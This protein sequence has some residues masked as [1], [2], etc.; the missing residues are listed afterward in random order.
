[1]AR[2]IGAPVYSEPEA[3]GKLGAQGMFSARFGTR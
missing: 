3:S 2:S 1:M